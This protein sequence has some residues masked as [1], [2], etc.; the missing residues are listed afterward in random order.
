[1]VPG[2]GEHQGRCAIQGSECHIKLVLKQA[3]KSLT[4]EAGCITL[5]LVMKWLYSQ[6]ALHITRIGFAP[7]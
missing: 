5:A 4:P 2:H 6:A 7:V 1:M 3:E